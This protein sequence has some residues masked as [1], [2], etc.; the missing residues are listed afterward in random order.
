MLEW[1]TELDEKHDPSL[2]NLELIADAETSIKRN[3]STLNTAIVARQNTVIFAKSYDRQVALNEPAPVYSVTKSVIATLIG[4]AIE[5]QEISSIDAPLGTLLAE[6]A[7]AGCSDAVRA[8]TLHQM[9]SMT[10][11]LTW[12]PSRSGLEPLLNRILKQPSWIKA[13]LAL[14]VKKTEQGHFNYNSAVS[15]LLSAVLTHATGQSA[16]DLAR[17][18]IFNPLDITQYHWEKDAEGY[19]TGGWG[20]SLCPIDMTKLGALYIQGGQWNGQRLISTHWVEQMWTEHTP[21][22]GYQWWKRRARNLTTYCAQG[23]GG[24]FICCVPEYELVIVLTSDFAGRK[25]DLWPMLE[26]CWLPAALPISASI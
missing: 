19:S 20:L 14:P 26:T 11:G 15:H 5:Q 8:I 10:T 6:E 3:F 25:K 9:L 7:T 22:Y 13:T 12:P 24:Q 2:F 17:E 16:E 4:S 1:R 21:G 18:R 23:L